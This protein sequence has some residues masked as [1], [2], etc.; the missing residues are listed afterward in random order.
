MEITNFGTNK[1]GE[2]VKISD[3]PGADFAFIPNPLP[4]AWVWPS[5]LWPLLLEAHKCLARLDGVGM[6]VP[7][8]DLL[9]IPLQN[10]EALHSTSLERIYT[11]PE[12]LLL[13]QMDPNDPGLE[14]EQVN[15]SRE[16]DNYKHALRYH[17]VGSNN[18][19]L[20]LRLIRDLH[21][22]LLT[23]VRSEDKQPG[24]FRKTQN[25]I[26]KPARYVPPPPE[27]MFRGRLEVLGRDRR[28]HQERIP[29][30][31][32]HFRPVPPAPAQ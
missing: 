18:L 2:L 19:P 24:E 4:P 11:T 16:A 13:F 28:D 7:D 5:E 31:R 22:I 23:D 12:Q 1:T 29:Q 8:P 10:R 25:Q 15:P 6:H 32:A 17:S 21:R 26:G 27:E 20:S 30:L 14:K 9:L 3:F